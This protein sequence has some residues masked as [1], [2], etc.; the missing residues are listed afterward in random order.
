MPRLLRAEDFQRPDDPAAELASRRERRIREAVEDGLA[1]LATLIGA[2][3]LDQVMNI[4]AILRTIASREALDALLSAYKPV[5]E[6]F[7]EAAEAE[8]GRLGAV[9]YDPLAPANDLAEGQADFISSIR[10]QAEDVLRGAAINGLRQGDDAKA[11]ASTLASVAGLN[12]RQ[13]QAVFNYRRLLESGDRG[14]LVRELRDRRFDGTVARSV[15]GETT[16]SNEQ[17]DAMVARYAERQLAYRAETMAHDLSMRAA[18]GGIRDAYVQAVQTG[19]LLNSEV[20]RFWQLV[21]DERLCP[22]CASIPLLNS[23]GVGVMEAYR[24]IEGPVMEPGIHPRCRCSEKYV[25]DLTRLS[26]SP[27]A[28]A[29]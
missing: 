1:V 21:P 24:S 26:S 8:A 16:L 28:L 4:S 15:R 2:I 22:V 29:A 18:N 20:K 23:D 6:V 5:N 19:R 9:V 12:R 14:A 27:F 7:V 10:A 13:A 17:I 25:A 3:P 11:I